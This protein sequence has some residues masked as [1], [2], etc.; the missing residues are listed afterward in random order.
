MGAPAGERGLVGHQ[1][2]AKWKSD[3]RKWRGKN[4]D[5]KLCHIILKRNGKEQNQGEGGKG[6]EKAMD[7]QE[8]SCPL[9]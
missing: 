4:G 8:M 2:C 5:L 3:Q 6:G 7:S 1:Q 9:T